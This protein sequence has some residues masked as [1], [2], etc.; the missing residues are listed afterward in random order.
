MMLRCIPELT[1][2]KVLPLIRDLISFVSESARSGVSAH[3]VEHG[4]FE[5]LL[6]VGRVLLGRYFEEAGEGDVGKTLSVAVVESSE[7]VSDQAT[8]SILPKH[9]TFIRTRTMRSRH[10]RSIFGPLT[11]ERYGYSDGAMSVYPFDQQCM[12]P[13]GRISYLL[14]RW[15]QVFCVQDSFAEGVKKLDEILGTSLSVRTT[16]KLSTKTACDVA[17]YRQ[18]QEAPP[19]LTEGDILVLSVDGKGI[20][21]TRGSG[22]ASHGDDRQTSPD[23]AESPPRGLLGPREKGPKP[24]RKKMSYVTTVYSVDG[25]E[26]SPSDIVGE[27]LKEAN[28]ETNRPKRPKPCHKEVRA[29]LTGGREAAFAHLVQRLELRGSG[30]PVVFLADGERKL[31][32]M[33]SEY[34]PDAVGILDIY[35]ANE[36]VWAVANAVH[37][38]D[39]EMVN[40]QVQE[41]LK[42]LLEGGVGR[43][44]GS[45]RQRLMKRKIRGKRRETIEKAITYFVQNRD[46]M[47]YDVYLEAGYPI[48]S[49]AVE[50]A[51][52]HLVKDRMERTGMRWRMESAQAMLDLRA[53]RINDTW[54]VYWDY[55]IQKEQNRIYQYLP[56][57]LEFDRKVA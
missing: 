52:R 32:D 22:K 41:W 7:S 49:G 50:G 26:R 53:I 51:C 27:L 20:P 1:I 38:D 57:E 5:K 45:W 31:W 28:D 9:R 46:Q 13:D 24:G 4:I 15:V 2:V 55:H 39:T 43:L 34:I 3:V 42:M 47:Q 36:R 35:H 21:I 30:K 6:V 56:K 19:V 8:A 29:D 48:A 16:E 18:T 17:S 54:N 37:G 40:A 12:L 23:G 33:R 44:I 11:V 10:Y 14:Q 25:Y